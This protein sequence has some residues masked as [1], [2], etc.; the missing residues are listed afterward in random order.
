MPSLCVTRII[1]SDLQGGMLQLSVRCLV[2][3]EL[4]LVQLESG[5]AQ[6]VGTT[7]HL[8]ASFGS[9]STRTSMVSA[10]PTEMQV[11]LVKFLE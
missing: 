7:V 2:N 8:R 11:C 1:Q 9:I 10:L 3:A 5:T 6:S 4:G